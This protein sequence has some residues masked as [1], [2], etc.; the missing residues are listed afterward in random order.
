MYS[1]DEACVDKQLVHQAITSALEDAREKEIEKNND[2][3]TM[4]YTMKR[5]WTLFYTTTQN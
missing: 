4:G 2:N 3:S 5:S 1:F